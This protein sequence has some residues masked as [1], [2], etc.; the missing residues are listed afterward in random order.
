MMNRQLKMTYCHVVTIL[1]SLAFSV[2]VL[3]NIFANCRCVSPK[4]LLTAVM[5]PPP[6]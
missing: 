5:A 6:I 4:H 2:Y 3:K 1:I